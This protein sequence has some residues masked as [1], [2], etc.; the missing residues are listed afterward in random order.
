MRKVRWRRRFRGNVRVR[1][2]AWPRRPRRPRRPRTPRC[3][4]HAPPR[5]LPPRDGPA[6]GLRRGG[7]GD[8]ARFGRRGA[9]R[10]P[11]A[12]HHSAGAASGDG[13]PVR[14][15][16]LLPGLRVP[17]HRGP[18]PQALGAGRGERIDLPWAVDVLRA[19][20]REPSP[21][22]RPWRHRASR[23]GTQRS[24]TGR[25]RTRRDE[26]WR[27]NPQEG[28]QHSGPRYSSCL[29]IRKASRSKACSLRRAKIPSRTLAGSC[30]SRARIHPYFRSGEQ[31]TA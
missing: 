14:G 23:E 19:V 20:G 6:P 21:G 26:T 2:R 27:A 13:D 10:G 31:T 29:D 15:P 28:S 22:K 17:L 11:E 18:P 3:G 30:F 9:G 12:A 5:D 7:V 25:A 4:P 24:R 16:L 1:K 8:P